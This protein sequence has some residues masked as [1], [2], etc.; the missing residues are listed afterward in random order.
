L[1]FQDSVHENKQVAK[2]DIGSF[3]VIF[4]TVF[5]IMFVILSSIGVWILKKE[6]T[7]A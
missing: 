6:D 3:I 5:F 4:F 2:L 1:L 7:K